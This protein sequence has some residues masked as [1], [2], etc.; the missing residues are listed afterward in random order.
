MS[1][2]NE[3]LAQDKLELNRLIAQV[4][5]IP[6]RGP[7]HQGD[8]VETCWAHRPPPCLSCCPSFILTAFLCFIEGCSGGPALFWCLVLNPVDTLPSPLRAIPDWL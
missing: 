5:C 8:T 3:S 1:A 6:A 4:C 7:L 2:L